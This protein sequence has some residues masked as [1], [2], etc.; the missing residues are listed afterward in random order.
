MVKV[1]EET[2]NIVDLDDALLGEILSYTNGDGFAFI[3]SCKTFNN[4][5]KNRMVK[6]KQPSNYNLVGSI[7]RIEWAK[8]HKDFKYTVQLAKFAA[9]RNKN[10]VTRYIIEDG[11]PAN[12]EIYREAI[13]NGNIKMVK[14]L[15][16]KRVPW[17]KN[18][19]NTASKVG[20]L[21]LVK[22]LYEKGCPL[23]GKACNHAAR[24]GNLDVLKWL[25]DN[26][27][28]WD[29]TTYRSAVENPNI[30][31]IQ[32]LYSLA[33]NDLSLP[34]WDSSVT[35]NAAKH[36]HFHILEWLHEKKCP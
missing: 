34:W 36:E 13:L 4:I 23:G 11:C 5:V 8:S 28:R 24:N 16:K 35:A 33:S 1:L 22:W 15:R 14:W 19:F 17:N 31:I 9:R 26:R 25:I 3:E 6:V 18:V 2:K 32:Y 27:F 12:W 7:S 30:K 20:D 21:K 29:I 10:K